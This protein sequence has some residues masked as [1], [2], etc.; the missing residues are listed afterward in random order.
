MEKLYH[1]ID[2]IE[3]LSYGYLE[4]SDQSI[5]WWQENFVKFKF[6]EIMFSD[7]NL[8]FSGAF[9]RHAN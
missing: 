5:R 7:E 3:I 2:L 1:L 9:R 8:W 4:M 6:S